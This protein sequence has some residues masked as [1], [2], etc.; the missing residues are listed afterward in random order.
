[1]IMVIMILISLIMSTLM[2]MTKYLPERIFPKRNSKQIYKRYMKVY[3]RTH[4]LQE[5]INM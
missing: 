5:A 3:T 1:M 4:T 2:M